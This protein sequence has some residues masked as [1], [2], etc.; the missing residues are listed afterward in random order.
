MV[1]KKIIFRN[2]FFRCVRSVVVV[3]ISNEIKIMKTKLLFFIFLFFSFCFISSKTEIYCDRI[4]CPLPN[5]PPINGG[6]KGGGDEDIR[7]VGSELQ[8]FVDELLIEKKNGVS[9][10]LHPPEIREV[11]FTFDKPYEGKQSGYITMLQDGERFRMYYRGGGDLS[12]EYTCLAESSDGINWIRQDLNLIEY[13][14][15]K[16]NN[17]IWTGKNPSYDESHNFTPFIDTNP[18]ANPQERYKA[19]G[20]G[21]YPDEKGETKLALMGLSSPDGIHWKKIREEPII[22]EGAFDSQNTAFWDSVQK[23]YVCYLRIH[24]EGKRSIARSISEDFLNWSKPE[25]LDFGNTPLEHFYTNAIVQYFRSPHFYLGF[26]MRFVPER[27]TVG[28]PSRETDGLSDAVFISSRDGIK[29][30]RQFMEAFIRPGLNP[31]NWGS[32]HG[33][34][35]PSWGILKTSEDEFSIY[36]QENCVEIPRLRRGVLRPDGFVSVNANYSGGEFTTHPLIFKGKNL[37]INYSTSAVGSI[38]VELLDNNGQTI[39]GYDLNS[40]NEVY[41]DEIKR[42]VVWKENSDLSKLSGTP[43]CLHFVMK[44]ADLF[45]LKF[46]E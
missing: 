10:K 32:A 24:R 30:N 38:K 1:A 42:V 20:Y 16:K 27:K 23:K 44:D 31:N 7:Y 41:G 45:S 26:P 37:I 11:V 12:R 43:I 19:V 33:N 8:L 13:N 5:P 3:N 22:T 34:Q 4:V 17:I 21:R 40:C 29:F 14:G 6:G 35:T 9:F 15:S 25:L 2:F 28:Y 18:S 36:W 39:S 46:C